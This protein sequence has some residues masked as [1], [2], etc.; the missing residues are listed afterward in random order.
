[1]KKFIKAFTVAFVLMTAMSAFA[2]QA[3]WNE[4]TL[5]KIIDR[6]ELRV[7]MEAGYM[8]FE[9]RNKKGKI[10][11]FDVDMA[12]Q[13]AKA[14][15]VKLTLVNT[16]WDGIIPALITDKF[17]IIMSGMTITSTR[18]LKVNFADPY[19]VV[20]QGL[21]VKKSLAGKIK[22]YKDLNNPKYTVTTKL[23]TT[24]H[25]ATK[26]FFNKAKVRL[27]E[28]EQEAMMEVTQGRADATVYDTPILAIFYSDNK[29]KVEF[30]DKPFTFEPL[31]WAIKKGDPDFLNWLNNFMRQV[32]GDG[33]YEKIYNKWFLSNKWK[34]QLK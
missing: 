23:G 10:I 12:Q 15:G 9:M 29:N 6:G 24:G 34:K 11:G 17:D 18:N 31:A 28:S 1:M 8:P 30:L 26:K 14:M 2:G 32:R 19:I 7:G 3:L 22:S 27:F 33:T 13:M 25:E 5:K 21:I 16:A 20:G 4:S